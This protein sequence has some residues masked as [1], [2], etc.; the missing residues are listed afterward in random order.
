MRA[1]FA[2][3]PITLG[4]DL[5]DADGDCGGRGFVARLV[6]NSRQRMC[7]EPQRARGD[8]RI[9][10][11][12]PPPCGFIAAAMDLAVVPSAKRHGE[13]IAHLTAECAVLSE[14]QMMGI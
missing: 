1:S 9:D 7:V 12:L 10:T 4:V 8:R 11:G 6:W 14:A 13:L 5:I 2:D 3:R